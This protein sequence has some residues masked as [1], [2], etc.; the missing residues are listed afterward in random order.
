VIPRP[1]NLGWLRLLPPLIFII[2][3]LSHHHY[4]RETVEEQILG[5]RHF[6]SLSNL[7]VRVHR[8]QLHHCEVVLGF[9]NVGETTIIEKGVNLGIVEILVQKGQMPGEVDDLGL[10]SLVVVGW[11][12]GHSHLVIASLIS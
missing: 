12:G 5:S 2:L 1:N 11:L 8:E 3:C 9:L 4:L 10:L 6:I 7:L